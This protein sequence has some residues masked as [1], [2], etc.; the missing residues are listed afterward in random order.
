MSINSHQENLFN[1]L[2]RQVLLFLYRKD[3]IKL[4]TFYGCNKW[5]EHCYAQHYNKHFAP[6]RLKKLKILEIGIGGYDD[7]KAG[8]ESLR[9]WKAYFPNSMIYGIDIVDKKPLEEPRIKIFQGSQD[10]ESFLKRVI[11]E[12]GG[13]DII[14]DDGS[15]VNEH[16]IKSFNT[17][18]PALNDN[19][20]YVV[21]DTFTSYLPSFSEKWQLKNF[22]SL[23]LNISTRLGGSLDLNDPKT[24]MNFFKRLV[25][26]LNYEEFLNPGYSPSYFDKH[27]VAMHFYH[28]LVILYKDNNNEVS[29][30]LENNTLRPE[31]MKILGIKSLEDLDIGIPTLMNA[32]RIFRRVLPVS[33]ISQGEN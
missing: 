6:L 5:S 9:M 24:M 16:V 19:G 3:L 17:L 33:R 13:L 2:Q 23:P 32:L 15:H 22:G 12:T 30:F 4:A 8:G 14:I 10:D 28:N 20:I 11:S 31:I 1:K 7:P 29:S 25:D 27:I 21:E 26:C 18:F